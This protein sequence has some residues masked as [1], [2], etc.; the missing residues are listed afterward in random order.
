[1]VGDILRSHYDLDLEGDDAGG[2][3]SGSWSMRKALNRMRE[4]SRSSKV[5]RF[6]KGRISI[7]H[8]HS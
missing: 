3:C 7:I 4:Q 6:S 1:M 2:S 5:H 8:V